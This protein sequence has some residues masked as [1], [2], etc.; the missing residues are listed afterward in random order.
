M[1]HGISR[2]AGATPL[3]T[4]PV[5]HQSWWADRATGSLTLEL[6]TPLGQFVSPGTGRLV[7][8]ERNGEPIVAQEVARSGGVPV[9]PGTGIKGAVRTVYELLSRSCNP[10]QTACSARE[11]KICEACSLFGCL[12]WTGRVTFTDARPHC[13]VKVAVAA[14]PLPWEPKAEKTGGEFRVYDLGPCLQKDPN[15]QGRR[16]APEV[17][18]RE[19]LHGTFETRLVFW[20]VTEEELGRLLLAMGMATD[21]ELRFHLR[22]GGVKYHGR[23]GV[24]V[25]PTSLTLVQPKTETLGREAS[26]HRCEQYRK[27]ANSAPWGDTFRGTLRQ[28]AQLLESPATGGRP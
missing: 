20:N 22:L 25:L 13:D 10:F 18:A 15:G 27:V 9:L 3:Q 14:V 28:L 7:L 16:P 8:T 12:G 2:P 4:K 23:G 26:G 5:G 24:E 11:G 1:Y 21:P 17:V 6:A 19:V